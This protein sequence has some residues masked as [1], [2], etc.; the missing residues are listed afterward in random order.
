MLSLI[1]SY[2][3][4]MI[5]FLVVFLPLSILVGHVYTAYSSRSS[6]V[7]TIGFSFVEPI[8]SSRQLVQSR[9]LPPV[10][11]MSGSSTSVV[12]GPSLSADF[13][14][15]VLASAGSPAAGTGQA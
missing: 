2:L 1:R 12:S 15:Q 10:N 6:R 7:F 8:Q 9:A 3:L 13:I 14:N 4:R 11:R 5:A